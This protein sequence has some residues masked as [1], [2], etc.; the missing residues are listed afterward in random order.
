MGSPRNSTSRII[1]GILSV[2]NLLGALVSFFYFRLVDSTAT[3]LPNVGLLE[4]AY[5]IAAFVVLL[6]IGH[7][8]GRPWADPLISWREPEGLPDA[9]IAITRQRA[10]A[11]P[12]PPA[13]ITGDSW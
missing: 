10:L 2:G 7:G 4:I 13:G 9:T 6:F 8:V 5:S 12:F 1:L 3:E 11:L